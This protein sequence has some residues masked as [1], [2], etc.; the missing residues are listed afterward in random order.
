ML[1]Q[2]AQ[3]IEELGIALIRLAKRTFPTLVGKD[4]DRLLWERFYQALLPKWKRK[5][6][7]PKTDESFENLFGHA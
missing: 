6:G 4:L 1:T 5:V 3:S 2:D 7:A